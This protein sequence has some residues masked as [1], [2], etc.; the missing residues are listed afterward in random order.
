[1]S[2]VCVQVRWFEQQIVK[3]RRKRDFVAVPQSQPFR[4]NDPYYGSQWYLVSGCFVPEF[5]SQSV[6]EMF[7]VCEPLAL[8]FLPNYIGTCVL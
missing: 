4:L 6:F 5:L 7:E 2:L 8:S 3:S 1:M